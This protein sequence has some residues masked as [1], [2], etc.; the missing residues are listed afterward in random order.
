M[1]TAQAIA[2]ARRCPH[3]GPLV[4]PP[5]D[6]RTCGDGSPRHDCRAGRGVVSY[7]DCVVCIQGGGPTRVPDA[8]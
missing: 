3:R 4:P 2:A 1:T 5:A 8:G 6:C 7:A